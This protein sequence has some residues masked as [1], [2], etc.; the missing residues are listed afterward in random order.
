MQKMNFRRT[1]AML[2]AVMLLSG[3][4]TGCHK[5]GGSNP[6]AEKLGISLDHSY[7]AEEMDLSMDISLRN[8]TLLTE[9]TVLIDGYDTVDYNDHSLLYTISTGE[10]KELELTYP[11][12]LKDGAEAYSYPPV[13]NA[14]GSLSQLWSAYWY[15][16]DGMDYEDL[17]MTLVTY[18]ANFEVQDTRSLID[19]FSEGS[20]LSNLFST[21][22][23]NYLAS[24][25]DN[26][27]NMKLV[28]YDKDFKKVAD[29]DA[30][31]QYLES[32]F[33]LPDGSLCLYYQDNNWDNC[34]GKLDTSSHTVSKIEVDGL[35]Q[36]YSS[37]FAGH[38][39]PYDILVNASEYV[40]GIDL[41]KGTC[42]EV[43]NWI[44]S[45]FMGDNIRDVLQLPDG[46]FLVCEEINT[47]TSSTSKLWVLSPRDPD[48]LK[49]VKL[50]TMACLYL[51]TELG[52][53]INEYNRSNGEC[54]IAVTSYDKYNT[55]EDYEA[56]LEKFKTDMTSGIVADIICPDGLEFQS[57]A[58]KGIFLDLTDKM[59]GM[60]DTYFTSVFDALKYRDKLYRITPSFS[61]QTLAAKTEHVGD[62]QG[63]DSKAFLELIDEMPSDMDPFGLSMTKE[64]ALDR[65]VDSNLDAFIDR[66]T[67]TCNFNTPEFIAFLEICN[68]FS[69]TDNMDNWTDEQWDDY[70]EEESY[71]Y[72]KDKSL[73][74]PCYLY[75]AA[76][77][78]SNQ[79]LYFEDEDVT[80]VGYP[81]ADGKGNGGKFC[82]DYTV[83]ISANTP[84]ADECWGIIESLL[85]ESSQDEVDYSFPVRRSSFDKVCERSKQRADEYVSGVVYM[86]GDKEVKIPPVP[87]GF[88]D[89][90][91]SY[92]DGIT[93]ISEYDQQVSDIVSE[94]AGAYFAGDKTAEK[95]A[96][97]IQSRVSLYISEQVG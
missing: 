84:Y 4:V 58:N 82:C 75:D 91:R 92:I 9:D 60:E 69:D 63:L 23:G 31:I 3:T 50:I 95:A 2:T 43:I 21:P 41:D 57:F 48:E 51:P 17:G 35:P 94:E 26:N 22:D 18:D 37:V 90:M 59:A 96:E 70:N 52:T 83:A 49:D 13:A 87:D 68:R 71:Q 14:D 76:D 97:N 39:E 73:F 1:A 36:W 10:C 53:A 93:S 66:N 34:F 47:R 64:Y 16:E 80:Y 78:W 61:L 30:G 55:D 24:V 25:Y 89:E 45:D 65:L 27:G 40:Y 74:Y 38:V 86:R 8:M 62:R 7:K 88:I 54:R 20:S 29:V 12:E 15:S 85:S 6:V 67:A 44:N 79:Y 56:G 33:Y 28:I 46:R 81:V 19:V 11:G 42:E 5:A 77:T 32:T 72:I